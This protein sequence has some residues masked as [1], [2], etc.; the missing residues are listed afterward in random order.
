MDT[1]NNVMHVNPKHK[2]QKKKK[3]RLV[4]YLK[5]KNFSVSINQETDSIDRKSGKIRF[6]KNKA[7]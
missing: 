1:K 6:L 2:W 3:N 5:T 7:F 4:K